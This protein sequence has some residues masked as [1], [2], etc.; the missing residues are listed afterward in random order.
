MRECERKV[1]MGGWE[2]GEG[3]VILGSAWGWRTNGGLESTAISCIRISCNNRNCFRDRRS[4]SPAAAPAGADKP[5]LTGTLP[6]EARCW[7]LPL[8]TTSEQGANTIVMSASL[9]IT[10]RPGVTTSVKMSH[11]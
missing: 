10:T 6:D 1:R 2:G 4:Q 8:S 5:T 9:I 7:H 11:K 3:G